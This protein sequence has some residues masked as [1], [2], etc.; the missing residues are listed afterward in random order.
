M[1]AV[2]SLINYDPTIYDSK[3]NIVN[4]ICDIE[5]GGLFANGRQILSC[6]NDLYG[7]VLKK[8]NERIGRFINIKPKSNRNEKST[9]IQSGR[10]H[11]N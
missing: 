8:Y 1:N 3:Y 6:G 5:R 7:T 9:G 11:D 10:G 4:L 2:Y